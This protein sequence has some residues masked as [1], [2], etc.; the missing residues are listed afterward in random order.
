MLWLLVVV[1]PGGLPGGRRTYAR[2]CV[3]IQTWFLNSVEVVQV[4]VLAVAD[5]VGHAVTLGVRRA[6]AFRLSARHNGSEVS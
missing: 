1:M 3:K 6:E 5:Q 2:P 4:D